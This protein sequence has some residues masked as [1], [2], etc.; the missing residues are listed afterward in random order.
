MTV[1]K[2]SGSAAHSGYPL[3]DCCA[4]GQAVNDN[5]VTVASSLDH[6][7]IPG[8]EHH[9]SIPEDTY[10]LGM[11]V[12]NEPGLHEIAPMPPVEELVADMLKY[13]LDESD[14]DR[15]FVHFE[16]T[17]TVVLLIN[18]LGGMS[19]FELEALTTVTK[20][21]LKQKYHLEPVR[22]LAQCF[23]TSLNAPGWSTSL[24]NLSGVAKTS[25]TEVTAL[26]SLLDADTTAPSWPRNGYR[27]SLTTPDTAAATKTFKADSQQSS[28]KIDGGRLEK[29]LRSACNA[30]IEAEPDLTKWDVQMG[31]GDCGEAVLNMCQGVLGKLNEGLTKNGDLLHILDEIEEAIELVGGTLGAIISILVASFTTNL[32]SLVASRHDSDADADLIS[33][34]AGAA[35]RNLMSYTSARRD[36]RTVMDALIPFCE[37]F[38]QEKDFAKAVTAAEQGARST[39]GMVAKFGRGML[40]TCSKWHC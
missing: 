16:P 4:I 27:Q 3:E 18:N 33:Q 34:A 25:K 30:A 21:V 17:D 19:I 24:L 13:C 14:P 37:A 39:A 29:A 11:G 32:R 9:R 6:C 8:R 12:H 5:C 31:D 26:L 15:A 28:L 2:L 22:T 40:E 20:Q 35:L 10:V 1:L 36:G 38:E 23:E 7:H